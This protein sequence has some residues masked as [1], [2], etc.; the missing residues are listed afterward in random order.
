MGENICKVYLYNRLGKVLKYEGGFR[1]NGEKIYLEG[2][3]ILKRK[4][5]LLNLT[6][7]EENE[8][9]EEVIF[10]GILKENLPEG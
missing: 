3:G 7:D 5:N 4:K 1:R 8:S 9:F 6:G 2:E 10:T